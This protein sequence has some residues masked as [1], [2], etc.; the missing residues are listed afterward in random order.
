LFKVFEHILQTAGKDK[1]IAGNLLA[2]NL[3]G[4]VSLLP[5]VTLTSDRADEIN[6]I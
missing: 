4:E 1:C 2:L 6:V 3:N 5:S